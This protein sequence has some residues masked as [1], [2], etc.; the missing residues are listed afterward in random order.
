[1]LSR[2]PISATSE[3]EIEKEI[4][5]LYEEYAKQNAQKVHDPALEWKRQEKKWKGK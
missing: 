2:R 4:D 5:K 3:A 1:L